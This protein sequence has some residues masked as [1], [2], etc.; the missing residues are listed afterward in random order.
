MN[1]DA[2]FSQYSTYAPVNSKVNHQE[3]SEDGK[4]L[5]NSIE[6][7]ISEQ[8]QKRSYEYKIQPDLYVRYE[9]ITNEKTTSSNQN[10]AY[11][12]NYFY[13]GSLYSWNLPSEIVQ[14][15]TL[16]LEIIDS[17]NNK[18]IW[19]AS[20]ELSQFSDSRKPEEILEDAVN[21]LFDTYLYRARSAKA[22]ETLK[23][24]K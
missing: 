18:P 21:K 12:N 20:I 1:D 19:Q 22:D 11:R 17:Q 10:S 24:S 5:I 13:P 8:M 4:K 9:L 7:N 14:E 15:A 2:R 23:S 16:L 6:S 3:L